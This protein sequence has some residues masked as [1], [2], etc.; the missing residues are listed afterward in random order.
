MSYEVM[1]EFIFIIAYFVKTSS[2]K[3]CGN[4]NNK[5]KYA[6]KLYT[7]KGFQEDTLLEKSIRKA[8]M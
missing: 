5:E 2:K 6:Q 4:L 3:K 8:V 1:V 7:V